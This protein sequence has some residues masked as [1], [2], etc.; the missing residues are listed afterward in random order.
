MHSCKNG[1][2][3][4][5]FSSAAHKK[6]YLVTTCQF[7]S[8]QEIVLS[9]HLSVQQLTKMVLSHHLSVQQLTK[10][11]LSHHLSLQQLTK[12]V[13]GHCLSSS[14]AHKKWYLVTTYQ[15]SS[16]QKMALGPFLKLLC[17][18]TVNTKE[19]LCIVATAQF[20][21]S[22]LTSIF[23]PYP[24]ISQRTWQ[25]H[26][27]MQLVL[28]CFFETPPLRM[29]CPVV[30]WQILSI[31]GH[32]RPDT[33]AKLSGSCLY[34]FQLMFATDIHKDAFFLLYMYR[35]TRGLYEEM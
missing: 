29:A 15:F 32:A 35:V 19:L 2:S 33:T 9:H 22:N 23:S 20:F 24:R 12:M 26:S 4:P 28:N 8:S 7:S 3:A 14:T 25:P 17:N 21:L 31:F 10:M 5:P 1:I 27:G 11:V 13:L 30:G 34:F 18:C 16:S 6:W